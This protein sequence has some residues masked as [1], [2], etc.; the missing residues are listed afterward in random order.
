MGEWFV[1]CCFL[2]FNDVFVFGYYYVYVGF[3]GRVFNVF[4]I[5]NCFV[6]YN[7]DRNCGY[8]FFY[9]IGFQFVVFYQFLQCIYQCYVGICN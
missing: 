5:V 9:W 1:F 4:Q 7:F 2:Y 8:Y 6:V 3:C